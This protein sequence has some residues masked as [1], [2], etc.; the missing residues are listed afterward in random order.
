MPNNELNK[1]MNKQISESW[2]KNISVRA[3][4]IENGT[5]YTYTNVIVPWV[6]EQTSKFCSFSN[7]ILDIGCGCGF[8]TSCIFQKGYDK[9]IG[10]D[11]SKKSIEYANSKYSKIQFQNSDICS[12]IF[13]D[14][15][16][17]VFAV[18]TLNN[19]PNIDDFFMN[20]NRI[21]TTSGKI[22]VV[23]PH[24]C[25]WPIKHL[26]SRFYSYMEEKYYETYFK[27]KGRQDYPST[28]YY[29]HR[30]IETY[31]EHIRNAN[32]KIVLVEELCELGK[33]TTPDLIGIVIEKTSD[34]L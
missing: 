27:T 3:A 31:C 26:K 17:A 20:A 16:D 10:I 13:N 15:F 14:K 18:M 30:S 6:L 32:F 25:F 9:I 11:I 34:S 1:K 8:L 2:D 33:D 23:L 5:D 29:F 24:P 22:I 19:M 4:D 28:V 12:V 7:K 21:L